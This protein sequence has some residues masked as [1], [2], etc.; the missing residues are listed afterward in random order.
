[1]V[2]YLNYS[3][4]HELMLNNLVLLDNTNTYISMYK[5]ESEE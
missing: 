3:S 4:L 1:M 5:F 2:G